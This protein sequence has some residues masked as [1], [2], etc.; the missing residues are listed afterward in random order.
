MVLLA[1]EREGEREEREEDGEGEH[2]GAE[3]RGS[4]RR[5]RE[6]GVGMILDAPG[7][8]SPLAHE[9]GRRTRDQIFH[10]KPALSSK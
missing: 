8:H 4:K 3:Q 2:S 9:D 7:A 1:R 10:S 6:R 5:E